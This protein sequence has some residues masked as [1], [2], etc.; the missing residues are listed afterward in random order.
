MRKSFKGFGAILF[1]LTISLIFL[2]ISFRLKLLNNEKIYLILIGKRRMEVGQLYL[3]F[4][5]DGNYARSCHTSI[6]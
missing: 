3:S 2:R 1:R 6:M 5:I 4:V